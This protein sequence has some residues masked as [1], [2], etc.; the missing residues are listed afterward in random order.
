MALRHRAERR[1][2]VCPISPPEPIDFEPR[3]GGR[4]GGWPFSVES[5]RPFYERAQATW[6]GAPFDY[7]VS[8]WADSATPALT[9]PG[10]SVV[11]KVCH[12]GPSDVFSLR[13][14]DDLL[15]AENVT[16]LTGSTAAR[17]E[18]DDRGRSIRRVQVVRADGSS[19]AVAAR[20]VVLAAGGVENVQLL[21]LSDGERPGTGSRNDNLGR[22]I[23]DH[24][25]FRMGTI[26]PRDAD[27]IPRLGLYDL[28]WV[29]RFMISAFLTLSEDLKRAEDLRNLSAVLTPKPASFGTPAHRAISAMLATRRG[30]RPAHLIDDIRAI[31]GAPGDTMKLLR[32][33]GSHYRE[34]R[35]GWSH[36][37][38]DA[39]R[40]TSIELHAAT[41]QRPDRENRITLDERRDRL[42]RRRAKLR[43][44]W[45]PDDK[46]SIQRSIRIL[47]DELEAAGIG[48]FTQWVEFDG[49]GRPVWDGIHH[50]M[51]GTR[52][53]PDPRLGVVDTDCRVHGADNLYV[54]GSSVF[55]NGHGYANP[56][57]TLLALGIRLADHIKAALG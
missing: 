16:V 21:L 1:P 44:R 52:M 11:T 46:A 53:H 48:R 35:G 13:Y 29:G 51:G 38:V 6:V 31:A 34:Y 10:D 23:T 30:E 12:H 27:V 17:L 50:P 32:S 37:G 43:W 7:A 47:A 19:F 5:L 9:L 3:G 24:P 22:H 39:S 40:F 8:S 14:R 28:R 26:E 2:P 56:T 41:E 45:S 54:A 57:L 18:W 20:M 4:E 25:E 49:P 15:A 42:G 55:P 33:H 36:P